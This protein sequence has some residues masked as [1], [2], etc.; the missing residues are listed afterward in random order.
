[1]SSEAGKKV[2][3]HQ[4]D[5]LRKLASSLDESFDTAVRWMHE[6]PGR[7]ITCGLG[8]SGHIARKTSGTLAST[9]SPSLFLHAA[10][11]M[12]G[13]L[14]MV[15]GSDLVLMYSHSGE[16][17]ELMK[18]F[19]SIRAIGAK[20]ILI[21]GRA[22]SSCA[23]EADLVLSTHVTEESCPNNLAPTTSTTA[24]LALS[25]A[26]AVAVMEARGFGSEDFAR[27][28]PAG[29]LGKRLLLTVRDV[30]RG[31]ADIALVGPEAKY[32][33]VSKAI[34]SAG[35]GAALVVDT[36][37]RLLGLIS[38][39]DLRRHLQES[40]GNLDER[41]DQLMSKGPR[42]IE[43]SLLAIEAFEIFQNLPA[44]IGEMPVVEGGQ[45]LGLLMLKD[46]I[47]SGIL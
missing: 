23:R 44:K 7:V 13:D 36:E 43:P 45:V 17:D 34:T 28:H 38:D 46:L 8:K 4:A 39:G 19:P 26:L 9:G 24:M 11:A 15:T 10:E 18:L 12:H 27:F 35:V 32:L 2:L 31:P 6:T 1:M 41:A 16:S 47:R 5:A 20:T 40:S 25:D 29:A 37:R 22:E 30:M 21:T 42:T 33:E 14:G 3:L